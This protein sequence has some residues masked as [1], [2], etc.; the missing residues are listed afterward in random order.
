MGIIDKHARACL[1][2]ADQFESPLNGLQLGQ[3]VHHRVDV[4]AQRQ[5]DRRR[6]QRIQ[7]LELADQRQFERLQFDIAPEQVEH[8]PGRAR[9]DFVDPEILAAPAEGHDLQAMIGCGLLE[10]LA[11]VAV[12]VHD[13]WHA[14]SAKVAEQAQFGVEVFFHRGVIVEMVLGKV[15]ESNSRQVHTIKAMLL[16][17]VAGRL[18]RTMGDP[19]PGQFVEGLVN[20]N[21][22]RC[23]MADINIALRANGTKSAHRGSRQVC[24]RPDLATEIHRRGFAIRTCHGSDRFRLRDMEALRGKG[25]RAARLIRDHMRSTIYR[26]AAFGQDRRSAFFDCLRNIVPTIRYGAFQR[27]EQIARRYPTAVSRHAFD[28]D[29]SL[30]DEREQVFQFGHKELLFSRPERR[31]APAGR[32]SSNRGARPRSG[33]TRS[34]I[35]PAAGAA[36]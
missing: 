34:I 35:R 18:H 12:G 15:Q 28:F 33:A 10:D 29:V 26:N 2:L 13:G 24:I 11:M 6:R 20:G 27:R 8:L 32:I 36:L 19:L 30:L 31:A 5:A 4:H 22:I 3:A 21:R 14:L 9:H 1:G 7:R 23:R 16:Q 25:Q 17:A